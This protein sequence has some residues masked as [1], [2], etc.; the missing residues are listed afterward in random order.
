MKSAVDIREI[1]NIS[2]THQEFVSSVN[3][4]KDTNYIV[5]KF[6][7]ILGKLQTICCLEI[8]SKVTN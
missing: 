3:T 1:S 6:Q 4:G 5:K 2:V 8:S 7:T